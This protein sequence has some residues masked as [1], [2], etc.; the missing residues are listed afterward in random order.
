L[1]DE[2]TMRTEVYKEKEGTEKAR[3]QVKEEAKKATMKEA[4][5]T[6]FY[7]LAQK[8]PNVQKEGTVDPMKDPGVQPDPKSEHVPD[9]KEQKI[10]G[11]VFVKGEGD[12][13]E[14]EMNDVRQGRLGDCYFVASLAALAKTDPEL[15]KSRVKDNGD[16]TYTVLF[17]E[18]GAVVVDN[19]FPTDASGQP[20]YASPDD[21]SAEGV[22]LWVML[23]EKAW[24]KLKGGYEQIRGSK[25]RMNSKDAMEAVSGRKTNVEYL[26]SS[27]KD[28]IFATISAALQKGAAVTAGSKG[29][30]ELPAE[31]WS[32]ARKLGVYGNHMYAVV[33]VDVNKGVIN[34]Y[35]PWGAEYKVSPLSADD[36]VK[37]YE[38]VNI[39]MK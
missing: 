21:K 34:L 32:K 5:R 39:S 27:N 3:K 10:K 16:G 30:K 24:A 20:V 19:T 11:K 25:V 18:G 38:H 8:L 22:E 35:N 36:F 1:I 13:N 23:I 29:E 2:V 26:S 28:T 33:S 9:P 14:V 37:Y 4:V 17:F 15:I 7:G 31:E 12:K 6:A